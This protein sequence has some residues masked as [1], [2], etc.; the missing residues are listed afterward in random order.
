LLVVLVDSSSPFRTICT[1]ALNKPD[2]QAKDYL[3]T[4]LNFTSMWKGGFGWCSLPLS[5]KRLCK[6]ELSFTS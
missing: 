5:R 3:V 6:G 4:S 2:S 1:F